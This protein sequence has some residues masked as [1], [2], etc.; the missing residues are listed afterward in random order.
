MN[1]IETINQ[2]IKDA[3][4]EAQKIFKPT[5]TAFSRLLNEIFYGK[6]YKKQ[7]LPRKLKKEL[8]NKGDYYVEDIPL[9]KEKGALKNVYK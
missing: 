7:R 3:C 6:N 4:R 9:I 5:A 1:E 2:S 8:K